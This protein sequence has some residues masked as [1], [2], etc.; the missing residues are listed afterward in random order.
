MK[1]VVEDREKEREELGERDEDREDRDEHEGG[2]D[3]E[4]NLYEF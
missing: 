3:E 2:G 1:R 4:A